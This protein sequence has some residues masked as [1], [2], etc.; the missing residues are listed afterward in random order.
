VEEDARQDGE[1]ASSVSFMTIPQAHLLGIKPI[2]FLYI[3]AAQY[4]P[5]KLSY[6]EYHIITSEA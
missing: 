3:P 1:Y 2:T 6:N 4:A 5:K